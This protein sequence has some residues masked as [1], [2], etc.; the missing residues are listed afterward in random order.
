[1]AL[2][3]SGLSSR[4]PHCIV[5]RYSATFEPFVVV[6]VDVESKGDTR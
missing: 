1:M 4:D 3:Q 5:R 2:T 6:A